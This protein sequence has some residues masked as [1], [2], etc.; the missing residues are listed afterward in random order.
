M[1]LRRVGVMVAA[2]VLVFVFPY[3]G[4]ARADE[5]R[6]VKSANSKALVIF[7]HGIRD[8]GNETWTNPSTNAFWPGLLSED[9]R[10]QDIDIM[11]YHYSSPLLQG[12]RLSI[13]NVSDQL[14]FRLDSKIVGKYETVVF[15][16]HSMGGLV[17]RNL[18]LKHEKIA[19][20]VPLVYFLATPTAGSDIARIGTALG[21]RSRQLR[22]MTTLE[23]SNFLEDQSSQ[24]R[25]WPESF[26]IISLC[27]FET[28]PTARVIVVD[29]SS[30]EA[31][32]T[33]PTLPSGETHSGIAKP[34]SPESLVYDV[35]AGKL[36]QAVSSDQLEP[37]YVGNFWTGTLTT[38]GHAPWNISIDLN[39]GTGNGSHPLGGIVQYHG[40][41]TIFT[42]NDT[43]VFN[44]PFT[45]NN[46]PQTWRQKILA[47][48]ATSGQVDYFDG[49][50]S[51]FVTGILSKR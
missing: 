21:L 47:S 22:A 39:N 40:V 5:L 44:V 28:K 9:A 49:G 33:G 4:I 7:V 25:A 35:F 27:A 37:V 50:S 34:Q 8:D 30:A 14:F 12:E 18:L 43:L 15:V 2:I 45:S 51:S 17:V 31:L 11:T 20:M 42:D 41:E 19:Q 46:N 10:F 16:A 3:F 1:K 29:R 23:E 26:R 38:P 6:V 24:W 13:S 48:G 36:Q 32:C